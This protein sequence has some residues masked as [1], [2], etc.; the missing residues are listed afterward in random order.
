MTRQGRRE[1]EPAATVLRA[2]DVE[3]LPNGAIALKHA[4]CIECE[5]YRP[6]VD[7]GYRK[8]SKGTLRR[9][10]CHPCHEAFNAR[11]A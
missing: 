9:R 7:F 4:Q 11:A 2:R 3:L 8:G 1:G 10:R 5:R 6:V